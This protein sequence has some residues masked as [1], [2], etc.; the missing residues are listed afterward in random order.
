V[1]PEVEGKRRQW[2]ERREPHVSGWSALPHQHRQP[3]ILGVVWAG[4]TL[5]LANADRSWRSS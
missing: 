3:L 2:G 4:R 1:N 5:S